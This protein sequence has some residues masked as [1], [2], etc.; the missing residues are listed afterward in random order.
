MPANRSYWLVKTEPG[1]YSWQ[2]QLDE[3]TSVWDG[4]R[5]YQARNNLRAMK[6]GDLVLFYHSVGPR[7]VVGVTKVVREHYQ[8][9]T[10]DDERWSVVDLKAVKSVAKPVTLKQIKADEFLQD[11]A[12]VKHSRLSVMPLTIDEFERILELGE[13][14]LPKRI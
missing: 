13:T 9:P 1:A 12:L 14:T 8:D 4:V 11:I 6:K 2:D 5:N 7:D 3:G 10:T